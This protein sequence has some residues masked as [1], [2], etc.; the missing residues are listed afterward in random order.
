MGRIKAKQTISCYQKKDFKHLYQKQNNDINTW[1]FTFLMDSNTHNLQ[2]SLEFQEKWVD[3]LCFISPTIL[4][5]NNNNNYWETLQAVN[6]INWNVKSWGR[7]YIDD[8]G[9]IAYS[10]R[11]NYNT[12]NS[13]PQES[14]K[15]I[16]TAVDYYSDLFIPL[17]NVAQG[18]KTFDETKLFINDMWG[19]LG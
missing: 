10:L 2:M 3:I 11:I 1:H 16:E 6:Y 4:I 12:L 17:L 5:C 8:F 19:G 7:F 9:D 18:N 15:E 14:I 13:M